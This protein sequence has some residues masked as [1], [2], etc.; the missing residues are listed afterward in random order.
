MNAFSAIV[1]LYPIAQVKIFSGAT[2]R[3]LSVAYPI[4]AAAGGVV[5]FLGAL[6]LLRFT[7]SLYGSGKT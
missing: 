5:W 3:V 7:L 1:L 4:A 6:F 2:M